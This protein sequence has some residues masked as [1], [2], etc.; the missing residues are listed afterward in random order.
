VDDFMADID[1][2]S[3]SLE[4]EL[5]DLDRPVDAGAETA[6]RCD[7]HAKGREFSHLGSE[8]HI[9]E[10]RDMAPAGWWARRSAKGGP[11]GPRPSDSTTIRRRQGHALRVGRK[12][13][14][15]RS[16]ARQVVPAT[17]LHSL[18]PRT[19]FRHHHG[20]VDMRFRPLRPCKASLAAI[21]GACHR[22]AQTF[23]P[24]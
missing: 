24:S 10:S 4:R 15:A 12:S 11:T 1:G 19:L 8:P 6:R 18:T 3:E 5:D 14:L 13:A 2:G 7:Q 9:S 22:T 16:L 21:E 23:P 20:L 17:W